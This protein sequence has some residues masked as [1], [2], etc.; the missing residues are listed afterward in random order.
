[1]NLMNPS[2]FG[3]LNLIKNQ[4]PTLETKVPWESIKMYEP[5]FAKDGTPINVQNA[6]LSKTDLSG[7]ENDPWESILNGAIE[8]FNSMGSSAY[9]Y[10]K[11]WNDKILDFNAEQAKLNRDFQLQSA[12]DAMAFEKEMDSTKYQRTMADMQAAGLNPILA[13]TIGATN[14]ASGYTASGATA[15]ASGGTN[16]ASG[17]NADLNPTALILAGVKLIAD[18]IKEFKLF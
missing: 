2:T 5:T 14:T 17:K 18:A 9:D 8:A 15:S 16:V 1:M 10:A 6:E 11:D 4:N 3:N 12:N 7:A 13:A